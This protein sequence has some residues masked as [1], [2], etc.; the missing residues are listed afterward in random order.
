M[1]G[2]WRDVQATE[3][4]LRDGWLHTGDLATVDEDGYYRI[5]DRAK[6]MIISGGINIY[7]AEIEAV[8]SGHP[9]I[10]EVAVVGVPDP[11]WGETPVACVVSRNP[12]L[13][14]ADLDEFTKDSLAKFKRLRG[15]E[16]RQEGLPR[17]MSGKILKRE[18]RDQLARETN[19]P[20]GGLPLA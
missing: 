17:G 13:T 18:I 1:Q 5:V 19:Q 12:N 16:L 4:T 7:P 14:L 8:L 3:S 11:E 20:D 9:D 15:L 10:V 6:D 2:Y